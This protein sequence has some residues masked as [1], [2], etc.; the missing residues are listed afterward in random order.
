MLRRYQSRACRTFHLHLTSGIKIKCTCMNDAYLS[1]ICR[2]VNLNLFWGGEI[3]SGGKWHRLTWFFEAKRAENRYWRPIADGFWGGGNEPHRTSYGAW[4]A[5]QAP[6]APQ[7]HSGHRGAQKMTKTLRGRK[8]TLAYYF[9]TQ[10]R[11][12]RC[13]N[14]VMGHCILSSS[15]SSLYSPKEHSVTNSELDSRAGQHGSKKLHW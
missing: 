6:P 7:T 4:G 11:A 1:V 15:S 8:Y 10:L 5:L 9:P 14:M 3:L 12:L 13:S 2:C